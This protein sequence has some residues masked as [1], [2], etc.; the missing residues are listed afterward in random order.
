MRTQATL[1]ALTSLGITASIP[2]QES[3][4]LFDAPVV[5]L[6]AAGWLFGSALLMLLRARRLG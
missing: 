4:A 3:K 5:P 6:P 2:A 1:F